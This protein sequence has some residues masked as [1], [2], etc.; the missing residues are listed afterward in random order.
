MLTISLLVL[1]SV[2]CGNVCRCNSVWM[3]FVL[4][5]FIGIQSGYAIVPVCGVCGVCAGCAV[6]GMSAFCFSACL[7]LI[8]ARV[9]DIMISL[10]SL[11]KRRIAEIAGS[12]DRRMH[13]MIR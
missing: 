4:C 13:D 9:C 8:T 12:Q 3:V 7:Q 2:V 6:C 10:I 5:V 1:Y 11:I